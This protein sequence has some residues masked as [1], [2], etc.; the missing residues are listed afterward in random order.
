MAHSIR[1]YA[2]ADL[3][4]IRDFIIAITMQCFFVKLECAILADGKGYALRLF[5]LKH[6]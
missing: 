2:F 4:I 6:Y 1:H 3:N 5:R